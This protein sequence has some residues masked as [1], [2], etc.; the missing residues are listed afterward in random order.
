M[1]NLQRTIT[2]LNLPVIPFGELKSYLDKVAEIILE[3]NLTSTE[4]I[5]IPELRDVIEVFAKL[6][7][8]HASVP[9][10]DAV[11]SRS[12]IEQ[13]NAKIVFNLI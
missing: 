12:V 13:Y 9:L 6:L 4:R 10:P 1:I 5:K 8:N 7:V 11:A 3:V 2:Q